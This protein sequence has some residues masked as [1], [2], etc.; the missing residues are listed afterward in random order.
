MGYNIISS[1]LQIFAY[2]CWCNMVHMLLSIYSDKYF[3]NF[4]KL[5]QK[6]KDGWYNRGT[7]M[8]HAITQFSIV[9]Y[10]S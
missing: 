7:S 10:Q 6:D 2:F 8:T 4:H 3:M 1:S 9:I 5:K